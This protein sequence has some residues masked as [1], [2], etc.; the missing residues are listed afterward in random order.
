MDHFGGSGCCQ[1]LKDQRP[2]PQPTPEAETWLRVGW[3]AV[4]RHLRRAGWEGL[5]CFGEVLTAGEPRQHGSIGFSKLPRAWAVVAAGPWF[6]GTSVGGNT[7]CASYLQLWRCWGRSLLGGTAAGSDPAGLELAGQT[8][9][10]P[11][12]WRFV[13]PWFWLFP[14]PQRPCVGR[15][16]SRG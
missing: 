7:L 12:F 1:T 16:R 6:Q 10:S 3:M 11:G 2:T 4:Y 9:F 5:L 14:C 13:P 15:V 8:L